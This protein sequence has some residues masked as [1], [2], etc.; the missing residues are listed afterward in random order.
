[1]SNACVLVV[2]DNE[3]VLNALVSLLDSLS[4]SCK[5]ARNGEEG[6][7]AFQQEAQFIRG[8]FLDIEMPLMNGY[9]CFKR[10]RLMSQTPIVFVTSIP[11]DE[12]CRHGCCDERT[13]HM[14]KPFQ[15]SQLEKAVSWMESFYSGA[16]GETASLSSGNDV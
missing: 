13:Q 12:V 8:V 6:L 7:H 5:A 3:L 10:I 9:E 4:V 14:G 15:V 2:D 1:M 16:P 11:K